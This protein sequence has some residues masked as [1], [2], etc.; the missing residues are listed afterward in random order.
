VVL[1]DTEVQR[2]IQAGLEQEGSALT[3]QHLLAEQPAVALATLLHLHLVAPAQ[4]V[5]QF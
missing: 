3:V 5:V 1:A 2:P 4:A